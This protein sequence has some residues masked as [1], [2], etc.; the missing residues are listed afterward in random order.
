MSLYEIKSIAIACLLVLVA[1]YST[2]SEKSLDATC[3]FSK[4]V[5]FTLMTARSD[6]SP[7]NQSMTIRRG[8]TTKETLGSDGAVRATNSKTWT[9]VRGTTWVG[10]Y[11]ELLTIQDSEQGWG[12]HDAVLQ[13]ATLPFWVGS[14]IGS[15][16]GDFSG[17]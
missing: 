10:D 3:N 2:A 16:T 5:N 11:G 6:V 7:I 15:C 1:A 13:D 4:H 17:D 12:N 8:K 9:H 14:F